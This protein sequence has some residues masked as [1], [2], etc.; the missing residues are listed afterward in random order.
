MNE[1]KIQM[2]KRVCSDVAPYEK[3]EEEDTGSKK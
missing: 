1:M 3:V 2:E